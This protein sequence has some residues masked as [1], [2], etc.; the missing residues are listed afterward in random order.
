MTKRIILSDVD[1]TILR[2]SLVL[3]HA[4]S[5]HE[6]GLVDL[7]EHPAKYQ[8]DQKDEANI[9]ALA[10]AY[11]NSLQG[12]MIRELA[13]PR[14][15]RSV[16]ADD[17][18]FYSTIKHIGDFAQAGDEVYLISGSPSYLLGQFAN[19]FGFN[20][21]GSL[22]KRTRQG[23]FTGECVGMFNYNA[24]RKFVAG[25]DLSSYDEVVAFG[26]TQSDLALFEVADRRVLVDPTDATLTALDGHVDEV[27][28]S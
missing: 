18:N 11:R 27:I 2:G 28:Y 6:R 7:G 13:V 15:I 17:K 14:F 3:D 5:L 8:A 22:Y 12:M 16:I 23:Q 25:L 21:A 24:K 26:D 10:E 19:S 9:V 1:G 20:Y 4:C